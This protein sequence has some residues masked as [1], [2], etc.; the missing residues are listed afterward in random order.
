[1]LDVIL[2][3]NL[4]QTP[5]GNISSNKIIKTVF[6]AAIIQKAEFYSSLLLKLAQLNK[7]FGKPRL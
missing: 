4:S 2:P 3:W 6:L 7:Q 5:I 1:M